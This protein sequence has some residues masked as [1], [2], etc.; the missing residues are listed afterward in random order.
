ME[1]D[2]LWIALADAR[3]EQIPVGTTS[4]ATAAD[5]VKQVAAALGVPPEALVQSAMAPQERAV[6]VAQNVEALDLFARITD[7]ETRLRCL[8]YL[9]SAAQY[10]KRR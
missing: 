9:R 10:D 8:A 7:S 2:D 3:R 5:F 6:F 4:P 1:R